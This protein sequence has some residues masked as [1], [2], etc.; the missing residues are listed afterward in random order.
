MRKLVKLLPAAAVAV[1]FVV[2][3]GVAVDSVQARLQYLKAFA[4]KYPPLLDAAKKAK[5]NVCHI[6]E[7]RKVHN[8]YG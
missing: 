6:G 4:E 7:D 5:C 2:V 3:C 1:V 8:E